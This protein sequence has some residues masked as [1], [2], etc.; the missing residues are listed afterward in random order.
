MKW[1][2]YK[3][4]MRIILY[5]YHHKLP[6]N[7]ACKISREIEST[8]S[9]VVKIVTKLEEIGLI[10]KTPLDNRTNN[11]KLTDKGKIIAKNLDKLKMLLLSE[12]K[13]ENNKK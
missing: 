4:P 6:T 1:L 11:L 10:K 3:H 5:I 12:S 13:N 9:H 2:T 7:Y 8:Y